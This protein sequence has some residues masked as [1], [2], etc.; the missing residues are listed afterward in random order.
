MPSSSN[1]HTSTISADDEKTA[2]F[3]PPPSYVTPSGAGAP[4]HTGID[5]LLCHRRVSPAPGSF[6]VARRS[7][8]DAVG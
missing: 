7:K 2:T 6:L 8:R 1:R 3:T 5:A 4:G